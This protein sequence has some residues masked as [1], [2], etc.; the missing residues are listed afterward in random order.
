MS[1]SV[2]VGVSERVCRM[3]I[4]VYVFMRLRERVGW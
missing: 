4:F 2:H 3:N 1:G